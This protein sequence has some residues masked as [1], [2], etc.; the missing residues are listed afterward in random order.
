M[1]RGDEVFKP[2]LVRHCPIIDETERHWRPHLSSGGAVIGGSPRVGPDEISMQF[3]DAIGVL[4]AEF[5]NAFNGGH[6]VLNH[7]A[8]PLGDVVALRFCEPHSA[9]AVT[10]VGIRSVHDEQVGEVRHVDA[11][12]CPRVF[13]GP[14][15][16]KGDIVLPC[17]IDARCKGGHVETGGKDDDIGFEHLALIRLHTRFTELIDRV[18]HEGDM[19]LTQRV[20]PPVINK[21]SLAE[22]RV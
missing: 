15:V 12:Q 8:D 6:V 5:A 9:S 1:W 20:E 22:R 7:V 18:G 11:E 14:V 4:V 13:I 17:D 16:G 3:V 19:R 10:H 21:D 2:P